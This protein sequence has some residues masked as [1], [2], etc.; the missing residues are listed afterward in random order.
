ME[1]SKFYE[2]RRPQKLWERP[3]TRRDTWKGKEQST[4]M[5][6]G[7]KLKYLGKIWLFSFAAHEKRKRIQY[8]QMGEFRLE[9]EMKEIDNFLCV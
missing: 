8:V 6:G 2:A 9:R 4:N 1:E 3:N 7:D 5:D